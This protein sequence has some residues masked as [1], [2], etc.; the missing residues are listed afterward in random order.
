[1]KRLS[2]FIIIGLFFIGRSGCSSTGLLN[3]VMS[4]DSQG[5]PLL[6]AQSHLNHAQMLEQDLF[7]IPHIP[8]NSPV[9]IVDF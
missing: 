2:M 9:F 8:G 3:S 1:M 4:A 5:Q 7:E 6:S